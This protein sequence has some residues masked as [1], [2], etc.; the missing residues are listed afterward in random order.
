M[1]W[2]DRLFR[3]RHSKATLTDTWEGYVAAYTGSG[4]ANYVTHGWHKNELIYSCI[5]KKAH[6][7]AQIELKFYSG[8]T[9]LETHPVKALIQAPNPY[10]SEY[11]FWSAN[12]IYQAL[13]G[14]AYWEKERSKAGQVIALWPLRPDWVQPVE[15]KGGRPGLSGFIY[16]PNG[17]ETN[18][19]TLAPED[20]ATF[21]LFD[22]LGM[23]TYSPPVAVA[24][25]TGDVDNSIT[26]YLKL[27]FQKGGTP[28]GLLKTTQFLNDTQVENIRAR[29]AE[30]YGGYESWLNPAVL[31]A[32]ASYQQIGSSF[33]DM[34]FDSLDARDEARICMVFDVPAIIVGAKIGLD[35]A[36]Y[37]N[38]KEARTAW[39]EDSLIP[40]YANFEDVVINQIIPEFGTGITCE[41]DFSSVTALQ[42]DATAKWTRATQAWNAGGITLNEYRAE[43]G[44]PEMPDG[45]MLKQEPAPIEIVE[46]EPEPEEEEEQPEE[47]LPEEEAGKMLTK[48]A[49]A[50]DAKKRRKHE[51]LMTSA[52]DDYFSRQLKRIKKELANAG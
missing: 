19:V 4:F 51:K 34:G 12:I 41:W 52:M 37:S 6:T 23:F 44:L 48:A 16:R 14:V 20:V 43:L 18:K 24:A 1:S 26:D 40:M 2:I 13:A 10:M 7:A 11:D 29:W 31:D 35:R 15:S 39:W 36:T 32:D 49:E 22:P 28:P 45:D 30:R 25:R 21:P 8:E 17:S 46:P 33:K 47:E 50:P 38:Y 5:S 9:E 42:E 27:F 3:R